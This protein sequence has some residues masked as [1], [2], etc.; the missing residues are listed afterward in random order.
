MN[1]LEIY[2]VVFTNSQFRKSVI[3]CA[4][5]A[6]A[7]NSLVRV[8]SSNVWAYGMDRDSI[9][10]TNEYGDMLVQFK[11]KNGGPGDVYIYYD[12]P[13]RLYRKWQTTPSKGSWFWKNIRHRFMYSKLTGD[14]KGKLPNAIN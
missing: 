6:T 7:Q 9:D 5:A 8:R 12:V 13:T 14:K 11:N 2:D 1:Y 10:E 3:M 4:S